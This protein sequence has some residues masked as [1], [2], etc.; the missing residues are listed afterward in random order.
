[1][2]CGFR[3]HFRIG[4]TGKRLGA[5]MSITESRPIIKKK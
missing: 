1:M 5:A 3:Q 4:G 2:I